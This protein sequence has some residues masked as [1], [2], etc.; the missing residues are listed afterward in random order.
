MR[1]LVIII[2]VC[3][4][5]ACGLVYAVYGQSKEDFDNL[6]KSKEYIALLDKINDAIET[7]ENDRKPPERVMELKFIDVSDL[8]HKVPNFAGPDIRVFD[9]EACSEGAGGGMGGGISFDDD[10]DYDPFGEPF[11]PDEMTELIKANTGDE[12]WPEEMGGFGTIELHR[13]KLIVCN[14]PEMVKQVEEI[15]ERIRENMSVIISSTVYLFAADESYL[16]QVREKGSSVIGPEKVEKILNDTRAGGGVEMLETAYLTSYSSQTVYLYN[17]A[18]HPYMADTD[19]SGAGGLAPVCIF[20]PII[21]LVREGLVVGL[22]TQYN[23]HTGLVNVVAAITLGKL[24][25]IEEKTGIGGGV[26]EEPRKCKVELPK[27]DL[28]TV[29]GTSDVPEG[30][31]LLLGGSRMKTV[32]A[33]QKSF[34]VLIVPKVQKR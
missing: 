9:P 5:S 26:E 32:Q 20:D 24:T 25:A 10:E 29:D 33:Q 34:V 28:Q 16:S 22:R 13:G 11:G 4:I 6:E 19:T 18:E 21:R 7:I 27:V 8:L 15:I 30:S 2:S 12:N 14:T 1:R 3:V 31:G 17:G 23:D